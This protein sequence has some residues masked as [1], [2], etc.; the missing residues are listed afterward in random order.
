MDDI[1][2][3]SAEGTANFPSNGNEANNIVG[4]NLV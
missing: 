2:D 4:E 3:N 1:N